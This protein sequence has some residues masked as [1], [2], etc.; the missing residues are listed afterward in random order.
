[1]KETDQGIAGIEMTRMPALSP[2]KRFPV[3]GQYAN[4]AIDIYNYKASTIK[5]VF[6]G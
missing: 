6:F 4:I 2:P 1:M 3:N 5:V